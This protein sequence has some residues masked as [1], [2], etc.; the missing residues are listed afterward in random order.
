[1]SKA[2]SHL[3]KMVVDCI[4][5]CPYDHLDVEPNRFSCADYCKATGDEEGAEF[6]AKC[7]EEWAENLEAE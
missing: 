4:G 3:A 1:M 7:W 2:E 6:M 5:T